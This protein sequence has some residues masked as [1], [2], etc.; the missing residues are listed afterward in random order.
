M[1]RKCPEYGYY[2]VADLIS[3]LNYPTIIV[4]RPTLGTINHTVLTIEFAKQKGLN[5]LGF[6][7]SGYDEDT[8]DHVIKTA[9]E[10]ISRITGVR[11]L[12]RLRLL[13]LQK[14]LTALQRY[15]Q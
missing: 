2:L 5:I 7:I 13:P 15:S 6:V 8:K 4:A 3:E 10:E 1:D 12:M 14:P 11:C 9:P